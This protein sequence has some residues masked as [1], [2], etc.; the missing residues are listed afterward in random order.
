[1][2]A[3]AC[4]CVSV[5]V[6]GCAC[7]IAHVPARKFMHVVMCMCAYAKVSVMLSGSVWKRNWGSEMLQNHVIHGRI[8][9]VVHLLNHFF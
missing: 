8:R 2:R 4:E 1:M 7:G 9:S 3:R 6:S 5:P